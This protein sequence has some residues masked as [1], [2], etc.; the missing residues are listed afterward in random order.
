MKISIA[1]SFSITG[2]LPRISTMSTASTPLN[3]GGA[4][5]FDA[6]DAQL[7]DTWRV[8]IKT[9]LAAGEMVA[10]DWRSNITKLQVT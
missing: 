3:F 2:K 9:A 10:S 1:F 7:S 6:G 5:T 8:S 4:D